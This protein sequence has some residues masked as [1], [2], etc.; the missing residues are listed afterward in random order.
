MVAKGDGNDVIANFRNGID[1]VRLNNF[2]NLTSLAAVQAAMT[3]VGSDVVLNLGG[4]QTLTFRNETT[5]QFQ[6]SDFMLP[7]YLPGMTLRFDDEFNSFVSSPTGTQGWMTQGGQYWRTLSS[8][9]EAE[10]YSDSSV[11]PIRSAT[12]MGF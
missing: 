5:A 2:T 1:V 3:Q 11:G 8:N 4:G 10:Y 7:A 12:R 6:A 9:N